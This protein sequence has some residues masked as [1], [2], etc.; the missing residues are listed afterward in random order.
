MSLRSVL[1]KKTLQKEIGLLVVLGLG[2]M[3]SLFSFLALQAV[4]RSSE[5]GLRERLLVAQMT[6]DHVEQYLREDVDTF[7]GAARSPLIDLSDGDLEPERRLLE[8]LKDRPRFFSSNFYLF[9]RTGSV[10]LAY[11]PDP[12]AIGL[13][14]L[15]FPH[16]QS[17]LETG[18]PQVSGV[19]LDTTTRVPTVSLAVPLRDSA[20]RVIGALGGS[21]PI[22]RAT[23]TDVVKGLKIGKTGHTQLLDGNGIVMASTDP[24][25]V[26]QK[27]H[28]R[29]N[30]LLL[31]QRKK[32]TVGTFESEEGL[33]GHDE[34]VAFAPLSTVSWGVATQQDAAEA[35]VAGRQ[36]SRNLLVLSLASLG[37]TLLVAFVVTKRVLAPIEVLTEATQRIAEGDLDREITSVR[38][39]EIGVLSHAFDAMRVKLKESRE[40]I[41][42]WNAELEIRVEDRTRELSCLFEISKALVSTIALEDLPKVVVSK[43]VEVL[44]PGLAA[45]LFLR[46]ERGGQLVMSYAQGFDAT[47]LNGLRLEIGEGAPGVVL[48]SHSARF[49]RS[50]FET[51]AAWNGL[52]WVNRGRYGQAISDIFW[53]AQSAICVPLIA[54]EKAIGSLLLW[55]LHDA[56]PFQPEDVRLVQALADQVA[57]SVEKARLGREAEEASALRQADALKSQFL[58]NVSHELRTPLGF[59]MGYVTTLLRQDA[60]VD[61]K[62][63]REFLEII[64]EESD[65][66]A[67]LIDSLLD[68]SRIESGRLHIEKEPVHLPRLT[69]RL[70]RKMEA[71]ASRRFLV[72]FPPGMPLVNADPRRIEQVLRNLL[73]N[74][75]KYSPEG[76]NISVSGVV[77]GGIAIVKV[78]DEGRGIPE[79]DLE[80]VF[81]RFYRV[82]TTGSNGVGGAGLGLSICR[83]IMEAHGGRIWVESK[84]GQGSTFSFTLPLAAEPVAVGVLG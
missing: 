43:I 79:S 21:A 70:V 12:E 55:T 68:M 63:R 65:K 2:V 71:G 24:G 72:E 61:A 42:R 29:D 38:Q 41:A 53:Q 60:R 36:L 69:R 50:A 15:D 39:D 59:I 26:L 14:M 48:Q 23:F 34:I 35:Q 19:I 10:L 11:P 56:K 30:L 4:K 3:F 9:D 31:I 20:G 25:D 28:H 37:V 1:T 52:S 80:R 49:C 8:G 83:G 77:D 78:S 40:E 18:R 6:A 81:E 54:N 84:L 44:Q 13:N 66:L 67:E 17:T 7:E 64:R 73:V 76:S 33:V 22:S 45:A 51:M 75:V 16:M 74:A 82:E 5:I 32:A 57:I 47:P 46:D 58:S 62:T 27:S